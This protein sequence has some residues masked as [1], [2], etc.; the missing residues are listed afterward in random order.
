MAVLLNIFFL[1]NVLF[2]FYRSERVITKFIM[3]ATYI[4]I[5]SVLMAFMLI[6]SDARRAKKCSKMCT[7]C[8]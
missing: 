5:V 8:E 1:T 6:T 4:L 3:K 7:K 2:Y